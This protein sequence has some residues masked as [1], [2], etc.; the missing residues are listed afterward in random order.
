M[1]ALL[2]RLLSK[3]VLGT[4]GM[5]SPENFGSLGKRGSG[6]EV[7]ERVLLLES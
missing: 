4:P 6:G 3:T 1:K 5:R 7:E 2:R